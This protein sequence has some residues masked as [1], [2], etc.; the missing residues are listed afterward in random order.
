[1]RF[2]LNGT[3]TND[4]EVDFY[5]WFGCS[6]VAPKDI[7]QALQDNPAGE[8]FIL[9]I[10][11]IGGNVAA[12]FEIYSL[13]RGATVPVRAEVQSIAASAAS[14]VLMG[15]DTAAS[16]V[17]Q[18][19]IHLPSTQICGNQIVSGRGVQ[20]LES[21]TDSILNAYEKKV[22]E[23]LRGKNCAIL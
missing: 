10:N 12:G 2:S 13:L 14:V 5:R 1:M 16:P 7:R 19:M 8:T 18:V 3:I 4:E 17:A 15:A 20:M 21:V 6:V 11:S 22:A 9:E 23:K